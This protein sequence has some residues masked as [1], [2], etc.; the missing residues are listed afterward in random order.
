MVREKTKLKSN[1]KSRLRPKN[2]SN[3]K[4]EVGKLERAQ[5]KKRR[6]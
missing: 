4:E 1:K 5:S 3:N 6:I 2:T